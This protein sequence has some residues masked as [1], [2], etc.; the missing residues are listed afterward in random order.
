MAWPNSH[1][2]VSEPNIVTHL[3]K[4]PNIM[5]GV[6]WCILA[7][8]RDGHQNCMCPFLHPK[9]K[10]TWTTCTKFVNLSRLKGQDLYVHLMRR[11]S[12]L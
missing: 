2:K 5:S 11:E 3:Q 4:I 1:G 9:L 10:R 12:I 7:G 8:T 6:L